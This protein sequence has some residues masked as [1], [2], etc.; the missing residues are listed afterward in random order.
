MMLA[1][2]IAFSLALVLVSFLWLGRQGALAD[3]A[4]R[5]AAFALFAV[6]FAVFVALLLLLGSY[7]A[8]PVYSIALCLVMVF[9]CIAD[10]MFLQE[11][12]SRLSESLRQEQCRAAKIRLAAAERYQKA[13]G[14]YVSQADDLCENLL[15][16][17]QDAKKRIATGQ[18]D[19]FQG[20]ESSISEMDNAAKVRR[21]GSKT[22]DALLAL[23]ALEAEGDSIAFSFSG[24]V[25]PD[26]HIDDLELC[27]VFS[28]LL[29]NALNAARSA[30]GEGRVVDVACSVKGAYL[31]L[32]VANGAD[33]GA[34]SLPKKVM[35]RGRP[36]KRL[37][38]SAVF[39]G[40][41]VPEHGWGLRIVQDICARHDGELSLESEDGNR[42]VTTAVLSC[43]A[44]GER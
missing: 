34:S 24:E 3:V 13:L 21:C 7:Q 10:C 32:R 39:A 12:A 14:A 38:G 27:S 20:I 23:K 17:I 26:L 1:A 19:A 43:V 29:D 2:C 42:V 22:I 25:P 9:C 33:G 5:V 37:G 35:L 41:S 28:N 18:K 30:Q 11:S 40:R 44:F 31:I 36:A 15:R 16:Q 6:Q 4:G 8:S